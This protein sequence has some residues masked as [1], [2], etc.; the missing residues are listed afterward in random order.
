LQSDSV[1]ALATV[2]T[3]LGAKESHHVDGASL[4]NHGRLSQTNQ[5]DKALDQLQALLGWKSI[6]VRHVRSHTGSSGR[7]W[8]NQRCDSLAKKAALDVKTLLMPL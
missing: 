4:R 2:V 1:A 3:C 5:R 6:Y 8:V 7:Q